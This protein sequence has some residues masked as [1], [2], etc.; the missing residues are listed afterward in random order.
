MKIEVISYLYV[1][2]FIQ[3]I[4]VDSLP[5]LVISKKI[6]ALSI[7]SLQTIRSNDTADSEK[8]KLILSNSL[9]IL[10]RSIQIIVC[11]IIVAMMGWVLLALSNLFI[12]LQPSRLLDNMVS[13][14][15]I[16]IFI[17]AFFSYF[18]LKKLY[19]KYRL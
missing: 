3:A 13:V 6:L 7:S 19:V 16:I 8:E 1:F 4:L 18:L 2:F 17:V 5:F 11:L 12:P 9:Q 15:G 14:K 10:K